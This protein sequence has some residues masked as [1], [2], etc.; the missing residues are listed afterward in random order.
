M[1]QEAGIMG[2]GH[3][4]LRIG[5]PT[6]DMLRSCAKIFQQATVKRLVW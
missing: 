1:F 4:N 5:A 2:P 3:V 6:A